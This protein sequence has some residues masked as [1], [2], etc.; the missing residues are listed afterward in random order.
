MELLLHS[1]PCLPL[2]LMR[3][4]SSSLHSLKIFF[5]LLKS[6][7][8][9][10]FLRRQISRILLKKLR[11]LLGSCRLYRFL[12]T[13]LRIKVILTSTPHKPLH[14]LL[15]KRPVYDINNARTC[16]LILV[17]EH[18]ADLF[19]FVAVVAVY[20]LLLVLDDLEDQA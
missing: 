7:D 12:L 4:S 13:Q 14:M 6:F 8:K 11:D 20:G 3:L 9:H 10:L 19:E 2:T 5:S 16:L 18:L 15:D 17:E 1:Y